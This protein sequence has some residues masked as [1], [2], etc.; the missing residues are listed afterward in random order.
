MTNEKTA[1]IQLNLP[2]SR[3]AKTGLYDPA[4]EKDSCGVGFVAD[5]KGRPSHAIL[6]EANHALVRMD[7]RGGCGCETNTGDGCGILTA[8]PHGFFQ[9]IAK[10]EFGIDLRGR[11]RIPPGNRGRARKMQSQAR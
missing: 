9:K 4:N 11:Q 10:G 5:M 7:H 8:L 3:P 1:Q 6:Q 2:L